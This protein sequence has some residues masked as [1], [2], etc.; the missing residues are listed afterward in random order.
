LRDLVPQHIFFFVRGILSLLAS[1]A[2]PTLVSAQ[3][4]S[5]V[6]PPRTIAD[7]T[8]ILDQEK[9]DPARAAKL[10]A[11]ADSQP[12]GSNSADLYFRRA[13]ARWALGRADQSIADT[14][15]AI[16]IGRKQGAEVVRYQEFLLQQYRNTGEAKQALSLINQMLSEY[17]NP[18]HRGR[19]FN[20]YRS[21]AI[22]YLSVGEID[23]AEVASSRLQALLGTARRWPS[24]G[25]FQPT[26]E[27]SVE[28]VR[29]RVAEARGRFKEAEA[30]YEK[31]RLLSLRVLEV[32]STWRNPPPRASVELRPDF[33][34][35]FAAQVKSKQGRLVEAEVDIRRALLSRLKLAG[36]YNNLTPQ[37]VLALVRVLIEQRRFAEAEQLA[38]VTVDIYRAIGVSEDAAPLAAALNT[39]AGTLQLQQRYAEAAE[40]F[41]ALD[42]VTKSWDPKR[43]EGFR[44]N[45]SRIYTYY[46]TGKLADGM[47]IATALY[48]RDKARLG[49]NHF[50]TALARGALALGL[51]LAR[52]DGEALAHFKAAVPILISASRA[53]DDENEG[54][55]QR[56]QRVRVIVAAYIALLARAPGGVTPEI[57][58]E[59][60]RI[61]DVIRGQS[62]QKALSESGARAVAADPALADLVRKEQDLEKEFNAQLGL[63]TNM[64]ALPPE[65]RDDKA[66]T[67]LRGEIEKMRTN[68]VGAQRE[69]QKKFPHYADLID[70]KPPTAVEIQAVLKPDEAFVSFYFSR[71]GG[72]VWVVPQRG[73][74]AFAVIKPNFR[75][76]SEIVHKLR[77]AL[78]PQVAFVSEIPPFDVA[79]AYE[80]FTQILKPVEASWRPAKSLIVTT[81]GALGLLPFGLLPTEPAT[82]KTDTDVAFAGYRDVPWLARTHAVT[83][84]PSAAA[85]RTLRQL[86]PGSDKRERMIGFGDPIFSKEQL[87]VAA[88]PSNTEAVQTTTR[89]M[90]LMRRAAPQMD[91]VSSAQLSLLPRLPDTADELKSIALALHAD[92]AKV[93]N[94]GVAANEETVKKADLSKYRIIVFAT[95]GL[96]PD[97]LDGLHQPALALSAPD[98]AG[99][100]GDGLLTMDEILGLKLD[101]D[102]VVL[103]ACNTGTGAGAGAEAASGLGRAF[104]YAGTRAILV[105]NWSVHSQSARQLVSDL[106]ARQAADP[107]I[108]RGEALRA[109]MIALQD[110]PG[111]TDA[112]GKTVFTYAHPLFWAPYAIIGDGG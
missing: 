4:V 96:V 89:G 43:A 91:N 92:P 12:E 106:F 95:H 80:L 67:A 36:K 11:D 24:F 9:P 77:L 21:L 2:I 27:S 46:N 26:W 25:Q 82:V 29:G 39:L 76:I 3:T 65:E 19:L 58:A 23:K 69:I 72:F 14:R 44:L 74:V 102:W 52:R 42:A 78:E 97:E 57:A 18:G 88:L 66:I 37:F 86:P 22:T 53:N 112:D 59:S 87:K 99:V 75:Q 104:F 55:V 81:N 109:A 61:A 20:S 90:P 60:F 71:E 34:M 98:V 101:A 105:T 103:S 32:Y 73:P 111:F 33:L 1:C 100:P 13:L 49:E 31:S 15:Q 68:R 84:V 54:A 107:K 70:P 38:R 50:D 85:L 51:Y 110:G 47:E 28:E 108:T 93:L 35:M 30:A 64:L 48:E 7:I 62:V 45:I 83:L 40:V 5:F 79:L 41:L 8:A 94:L 16:E 6:A 63:L 10:Q 17:D 56:E